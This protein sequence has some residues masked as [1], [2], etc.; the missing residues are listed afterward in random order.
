MG[1]SVAIRAVGLGKRYELE[2]V[3]RDYP[4]LRDH[5]TSA[6]ARPLRRLV[7]RTLEEPRNTEFW[8]LRDVNFEVARGEVLGVIGPN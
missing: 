2:P 8:A 6:V 1:D 4:T 5:L 3:H 7:G